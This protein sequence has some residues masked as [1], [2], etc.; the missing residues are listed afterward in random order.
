MILY[1]TL[2]LFAF[3]PF[4]AYILHQKTQ[5]KGLVLGISFIYLLLSLFIF[6]NDSFKYNKY[7]LKETNKLIIAL[8]D[9]NEPINTSTYL[10]LE[11]FANHGYNHI[12]LMLS[13]RRISIPP[14]A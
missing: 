10:K 3:I 12:C 4:G 7:S 2:A 13:I 9:A 1:I 6:L 14:K 11:D 5:N 8:I